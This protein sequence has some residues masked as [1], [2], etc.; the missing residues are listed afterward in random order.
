MP[1]YQL[2]IT[3]FRYYYN[4]TFFAIIKIVDRL[5][6][7]SKALKIKAGV[8]KLAYTHA[9][10][11]CGAIRESSSLSARTNK[12]EKIIFDLIKSLRISF[13]FDLN[14]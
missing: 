6:K 10:G 12:K 1:N 14:L 7:L 11:A 9:L 4:N 5:F 8:V 2:L 13:L 3:N